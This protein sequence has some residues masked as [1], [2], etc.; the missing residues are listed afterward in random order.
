MKKTIF[1]AALGLCAITAHADGPSRVKPV[2]FGIGV[3][4]GTNGLGLDAS[5]GLSRFFQVRG[6]FS[7]VPKYEFQYEAEIYNQARTI[8]T[9]WNTANPSLAIPT[10]PE[11]TPVIIQPNITT[12][13]LLLDVYPGR[14]FHFTVGAYFGQDNVVS[15]WNTEKS[16][17]KAVYIANECIDMVNASLPVTT[18]IDH[19]GVQIGDYLFTPDAEGDIRG[20]ARVKKIRPYVGIGFGRAVPRRSRVG[21]SLDLGAQY[22]GKPT[23]FCNGAEIAPMN[24]KAKPYIKTATALPVYP[25]VTLRICGRIF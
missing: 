11:D 24:L 10:L 17:T 23:Y 21:C 9:A 3:N 14:S 25:V 2:Q 5:L 16:L 4:A 13:H 15:A 8:I 19:L 6:G 20:E 7:F 1:L 18:P 12:A 22:W